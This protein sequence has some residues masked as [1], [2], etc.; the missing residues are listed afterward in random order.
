LDAVELCLSKEILAEIRDVLTR[1]RVRQKFPT[2]TGGLVDRFLAALEK[3]AVFTPEVPHVFFYERDPKDEPYLNLAIATG[4]SYL[5]S[6]DL[7]IL[8]LANAGNPDGRR[9]R[10]HAPHLQIL[11]PGSFLTEA[12]RL[13][14]LR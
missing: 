1:P 3:R 5:V 4:A 7:D 14:A 2:L 6:R 9:L 10:H 13:Q 11:N 8:D 12:R